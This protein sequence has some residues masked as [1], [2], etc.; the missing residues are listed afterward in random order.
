M[1]KWLTGRDVLDTVGVLRLIVPGVIGALIALGLVDA[2]AV[3]G[4]AGAPLVSSS[5]SPVALPA[6]PPPAQPSE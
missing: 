5:K 3:C 4:R 2:D 1:T 6:L